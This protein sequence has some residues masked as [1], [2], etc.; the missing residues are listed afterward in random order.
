[1]LRR[2]ISHAPELASVQSFFRIHILYISYLPNQ[3]AEPM[4]HKTVPS[5]QAHNELA[6]EKESNLQPILLRASLGCPWRVSESG[7][8]KSPPFR[9]HTEHASL[10]DTRPSKLRT[11][12]SPRRT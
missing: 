6:T 10:R 8:N 1:M 3:Y 4:R 9:A 7:N 12:R 5:E 11:S 2:P